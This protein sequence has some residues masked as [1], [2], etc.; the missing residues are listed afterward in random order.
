MICTFGVIASEEASTRRFEH[1]SDSIIATQG[2][3]TQFV[4]NDIRLDHSD[5]T[6][7]RQSGKKVS[8]VSFSDLKLLISPKR[9]EITKDYELTIETVELDTLDVLFTDVFRITVKK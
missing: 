3:S 5:Y 7:I 8:F 9:E 4:L 1:L 6:F 2:Q